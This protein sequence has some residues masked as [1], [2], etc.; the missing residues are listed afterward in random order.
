MAAKAAATTLEQKL[1]SLVDAVDADAA[2]QV[3]AGAFGGLS[4]GEREARPGAAVKLERGRRREGGHD[5]LRRRGPSFRTTG[6]EG[7]AGPAGALRDN[8]SGTSH[9]QRCRK[10]SQRTPDGRGLAA[11]RHGWCGR[12]PESH[13]EG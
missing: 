13:S 8:G 5:R 3:Y 9:L 4:L 6:V 10:G 12:A 7:A 2:S 1:K 11:D